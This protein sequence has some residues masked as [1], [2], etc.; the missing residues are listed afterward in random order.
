MKSLVD[1]VVVTCDE[2]MDTTEN[3]PIS[4][5]NAINY[6]LITAILLAIACLLL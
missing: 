6:W 2:I 1:D 4:P 3:V 5:N